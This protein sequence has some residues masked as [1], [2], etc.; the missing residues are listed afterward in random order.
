MSIKVGFAAR[1]Q[2]AFNQ[3]DL[4]AG[5]TQELIAPEDGYLTELQTT[6]QV[7]ITT[8]GTIGVKTDDTL[9]TTVAGIAQT[10][11]NAAT[12]G[13]RQNTK[14]TVGSVTRRVLKGQR[15]GITAASFATAGALS[16]YIVI[17]SADESPA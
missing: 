3:V 4:L 15:I 12:K 17:N 16:G 10:I 9:A 2:F 11:A 1:L 8:G 14:A 13:T 6:I 7:A 5:T